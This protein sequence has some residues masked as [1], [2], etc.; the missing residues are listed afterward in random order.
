LALLGCK[1]AGLTNPPEHNLLLSLKAAGSVLQKVDH[2]IL[3]LTSVKVVLKG[4]E[5]THSEAEDSVEIES[6]LQVL[7]LAM[8]SRIT[9]ISAVR[10]HPGEYD[11]IR[12][13]IH[14]PEEEEE[15]SDSTFLGSDSTRQR[16][17]VVITGFYHETP[18]TFR[19]QESAEQELRLTTPV[20][21][22]E[23]GTAN[24]TIKIDPYLWFTTNGL[25][26][27]PFIQTKEINDLLKKSFADVFRDNDRNG[28]PD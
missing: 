1:D 11:R 21:V 23:D 18:F 3:H 10:I 15:V 24:V 2:E 14:K 6:G 27:D 12:F 22:T 28:D 4:I 8:D 7:N 17:S 5:F 20:S 13:T 19:S 9:E 16:F 26:L 25:V